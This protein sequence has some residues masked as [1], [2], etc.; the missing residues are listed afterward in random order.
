MAEITL[1]AETGRP[2]GS[3]PSRRLRAEGRVPAVVYGLGTEPAS[4]SV[5]W[6]DLRHVLTT[7]AG[8][9]ALI[10]L[11][12]DGQRKLAMVKDLQRDPIRG[13]VRHVDFLLISRDVEVTVDVPI[14]LHGE[15]ERV[16]ASGGL[17]DQV[18]QALSVAA[19][20]ADIPTEIA[21]DLAGLDIGH[22]IRVGDLPLP[23]GVSTTVDPDEAVVTA[24]VAS[25]SAELDAI[26][27]SD[28]E[29]AGAQAGAE[30]E[31]AEG[32]SG[33]AGGGEGGGGA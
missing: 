8:L 30:G 20:P 4:V 12:L 15:A 11:E 27:A 31:A 25:S 29:A 10:D 1:H 6:R 33:G 21:V 5:G 16:Q 19:K 2:T 9:N 28:A 32:S 24:H 26:E 17:V 22:V 18:L 3:A 7:E 13:T 23:A 14:V